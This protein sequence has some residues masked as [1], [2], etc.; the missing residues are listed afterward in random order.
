[1]HEDCCNTSKCSGLISFS[2]L[3]NSFMEYILSGSALQQLTL[4]LF[5][6]GAVL[7]GGRHIVEKK[8]T[9]SQTI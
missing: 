2:T 3:Y 5:E 1:M 4:K 7:V 6:F 9:D 8:K